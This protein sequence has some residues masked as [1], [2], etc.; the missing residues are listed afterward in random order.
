MN[1]LEKFNNYIDKQLGLEKPITPE[2]RQIIG[3]E[4]SNAL[5][6]VEILAKYYQN[7]PAHTSAQIS[8]HVDTIGF[9][10]S[11]DGNITHFELAQFVDPEMSVWTFIGGVS[12]AFHLWPYMIT[13]FNRPSRSVFSYEVR[14]TLFVGND[15]GWN[16]YV[17]SMRSRGL[18]WFGRE[19]A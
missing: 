1:L 13:R 19:D 9:G 6:A 17:E 2:E 16:R 12:K 10:F 11:F 18:E 7:S 4:V 14:R 3:M 15:E 8:N 5:N